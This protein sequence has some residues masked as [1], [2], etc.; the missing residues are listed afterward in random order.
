MRL[1]KKSQPQ[2][3]RASSPQILDTE[4]AMEAKEDI[5]KLVLIV[6]SP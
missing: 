4:G 1:A 2:D 5:S 3:P 6:P